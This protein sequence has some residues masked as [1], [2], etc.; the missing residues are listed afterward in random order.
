MPERTCS[1]RVAT[2]RDDSAKLGMLGET[3][4]TGTRRAGATTNPT[5]GNCAKL[6]CHFINNSL[7]TTLLQY[8][9]SGSL[10]KYIPT[11]LTY[12]IET[13]T[14]PG[15][16]LKDWELKRGWRAADP[17]IR[18]EF[19]RVFAPLG[20]VAHLSVDTEGYGGVGRDKGAVREGV[21]FH[22]H[23]F[24]HRHRRVHSQYLP[25]RACVRACVPTPRV[26]YQAIQRW[27]HIGTKMA[28]GTKKKCQRTSYTNRCKKGMFPCVTRCIDTSSPPSANNDVW[29]NLSR[30][31]HHRNQ[32]NKQNKLTNGTKN[33]E[34]GSRGWHSGDSDVVRTS[35]SSSCRKLSC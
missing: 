21:V 2:E 29:P 15:P 7:K 30:I 9:I 28:R 13:E 20:G 25:V 11:A 35:A 34:S 4:E 24:V 17:S 1:Q 6:R 3:N 27:R 8:N 22:A 5:N 23:L 26:D 10:Y 16:S 32:R 33:F 14:D 31:W 19:K 12:H 18:P